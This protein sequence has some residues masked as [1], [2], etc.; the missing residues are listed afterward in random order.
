MR[1]FARRFQNSFHLAFY[2]CCR[3]IHN[4]ARHCGGYTGTDEEVAKYFKE[5]DAIKKAA[6]E[7][8]ESQK[9]RII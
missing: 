5:Q 3:E 6:Y 9:E 8:A 7:T 4:P 2:A 1:N